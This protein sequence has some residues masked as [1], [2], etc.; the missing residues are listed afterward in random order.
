ML[1]VPKFNILVSIILYESADRYK[2]INNIK[3]F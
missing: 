3:I 1:N 2:P